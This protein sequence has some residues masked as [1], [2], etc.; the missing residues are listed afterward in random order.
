MKQLKKDKQIS[1][2][3]YIFILIGLWVLYPAGLGF[4]HFVSF[5]SPYSTPKYYNNFID[6]YKQAIIQD[7]K[8]IH[9]F[10]KWL[11]T[12]KQ[13]LEDTKNTY[14]SLKQGP[15]KRTQKKLKAL[16]NEQP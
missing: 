7:E 10:Q 2:W 12:H 5:S 3:E 14:T 9:T 8:D 13:I 11:K 15:K 6:E 4:T 16:S 1:R